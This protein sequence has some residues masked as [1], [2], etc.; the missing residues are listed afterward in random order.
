MSLDPSQPP[1]TLSLE[2]IV[3]DAIAAVNLVKRR[4]GHRPLVLAGHSWGTFLAL[5][6]AKECPELIT[7]LIL[8]GTLVNLKLGD[9]LKVE[10]LKKVGLD[11]P[12]IKNLS[13]LG[14]PPYSDL[15]D[16][17]FINQ[18]LLKNQT[19]FGNLT[20]DQLGSIQ[21]KSNVYSVENW[22]VQEIGAS[23]SI[24]SLF[25][26]LSNYHA[27]HQHAK[28]AVPTVFIQGSLDMATPTS[29]VKEFFEQT[30]VTNGKTWLEM[31]DC[32][33]FPMWENPDEFTRLLKS[34]L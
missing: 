13:D 21:N 23:Q 6:V 5:Q 2:I 26:E 24:K 9:K 3:K 11:E 17:L 34:V 22:K 14:Q 15:T 7:K 19:I 25:P 4:I 28:I 8:V 18:L 12:D 10:F 1:E 30:E 31:M 29:L 20:L 32:A 27:S 33:H 16:V